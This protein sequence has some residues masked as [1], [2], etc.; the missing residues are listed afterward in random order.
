MTNPRID[1]FILDSKEKVLSL[2]LA[3]LRAASDLLCGSNAL[4]IRSFNGPLSTL[5]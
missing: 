2:D 4:E 1:F 3:R 5:S